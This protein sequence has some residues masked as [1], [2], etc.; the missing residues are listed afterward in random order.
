MPGMPGRNEIMFEFEGRRPDEVLV[1]ASL[2]ARDIG[3]LRYT[4]E[5]GMERNM[6][7]VEDANLPLPGE[8]RLRLEARRGEFE[9]FTKNIV[10]P[11]EE[12]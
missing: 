10:V 5:R 3:P 4:A 2:P 12:E 11:I 9:L 6:L 7:V 1:S 8:W